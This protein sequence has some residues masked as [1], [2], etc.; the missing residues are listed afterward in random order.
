M[1]YFI[2]PYP[3]RMA[4]RWAGMSSNN[5]NRDFSLPVDVR[6]E[7]EAFVLTARVPGLKADDLNIRILDDVVTLEGEFKTDENE[8]LL[9]ELPGGSFSRTLR[10]S[11]PLDAEKAEAKITD[12]LLT[13]RLPKAET[14]RP[15][16]IKVAA[17]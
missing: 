5:G 2:A 12:G 17:K 1:T 7:D 9:H 3:Y 13:L 15:K 4:R 11:A 10:L 16:I 6:E 8:Y 14:A